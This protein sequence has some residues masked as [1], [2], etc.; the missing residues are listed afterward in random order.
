MIWILTFVINMDSSTLH[1]LS[2]AWNWQNPTITPVQSGLIN[3]TWRITE[4]GKDWLLQAVNTHVFPRPDWIDENISQLSHYLQI[5]HPGYIFT[6][7][8]AHSGG[9]GILVH[10][11]ITYRVFPWIAGS[12][13]KQVLDAAAQA[14]EAAQC[15]GAFTQRLAHYPAEQLHIIIPKF[16]DLSYRFH[17]FIEALQQGMPARI[18]ECRDAISYLQAQHA[19]V[20]TYEQFI[21]HK[22]ALKRVTHHDTK[23][24][25]VLF[26]DSDKGICVID[27]DTVMPGYYI[28]DV[29]DM[30]RTYICPVAEEEA[31]LDKVYVRKDY[32]EAIVE[33][34]FAEMGTELSAFEKDHVYFG[35][36]MLLYMQALRFLADYLQG[37][38]YY[39][40]KYP[41]QNKIRAN[42]QIRLLQCFQESLR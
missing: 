5:H 8:V 4:N 13:A 32:V 36:E 12:H 39:G 2:N 30:F 14:K 18:A 21:H 27:L 9:I 35:G 17:Q 16:H 1:T 42:N 37:D 23:I 22:E 10:E 20:D 33:G 34:Y 26:D 11:N 31:D 29:G 7:P 40:A 19:L 6:S 25:N 24:S 38:S 41:T 3:H 15:F 28:S